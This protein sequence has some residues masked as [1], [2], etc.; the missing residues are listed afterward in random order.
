MRE[1]NEKVLSK[2]T[3]QTPQPRKITCEPNHFEIREQHEATDDRLPSKT[4]SSDELVD[5]VNALKEH[6]EARVGE[7]TPVG[8]ENA[9]EAEEYFSNISHGIHRHCSKT[10]PLQARQPQKNSTPH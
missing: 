7:L 5:V 4:L 8:E 6:W 9:K 2:I 10:A 3:R 1:M